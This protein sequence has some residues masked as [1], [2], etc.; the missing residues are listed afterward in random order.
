MLAKLAVLA[1]SKVALAV[2][3]VVLVGG[4]GTAA[5]V[6]ATTGHLGPIEI[7]HSTPTKDDEN[8]QNG[9]HAHT[10]SIE[11]VLATV[12]TCPTGTQAANPANVTKLT[13]KSADESAEHDA[14]DSDTTGAKATEAPDA[15]HAA[16]AEA[17]EAP[18]ATHTAGAEATE[19]PE[20]TPG[21]QHT[22]TGTFTVGLNADTKV[23]G[24][25]A[26][27]RGDLCQGIGHGV[28]IQATKAS[29]GSL[30]AWKVTLQGKDSSDKGS[31][32]GGDGSE[33][34]GQSATA[35][36]SIS[37]LDVAKHTLS[38]TAENGTVTHV[39][40]NASTQFSGGIHS[41][42]DL[43]VGGHVT[44]QGTKQTDGSILATRVEHQ[45]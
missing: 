45:D 15:T 1:Q 18:K 4:G 34:Q 35:T 26:S 25:H 6:A 27:T 2:L 41:L 10:V 37:A 14:T 9:I 36:G 23:N 44:V 3:G 42:A 33:G 11:G 22:G 32:G 38:V 5:A 7:A 30:T 39:T 24:E 40:V 20:S 29:D 43:H 17:T 31:S 21:T 12:G 19:K 16:G 13:V 28:E 8:G